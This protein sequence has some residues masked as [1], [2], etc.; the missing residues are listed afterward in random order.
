MAKP[1]NIYSKFNKFDDS[2]SPK[3]MSEMNKYQFKLVI[4]KGKFI[5]YHHSEINEVFILIKGSM[6]IEF[7]TEITEVNEG[8][9]IV[10]PKGVLN[11]GN[12]EINL[13]AP[14]YEWI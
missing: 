8:E 1:I 12:I 7:N 14:N 2:W 10:V 11:T 13:T 9:I 4:I 6:K 5:K 3:L